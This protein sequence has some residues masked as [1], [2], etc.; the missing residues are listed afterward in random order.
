M[1]VLTFVTRGARCAAKMHTRW[2]N[3]VSRHVLVTGCSRG[4][5]LAVTK[6]LL[7]EGWRVYG[8]ARSAPDLSDPNFLFASADVGQ[9]AS[10]ERLRDEI[11]ADLG[12]AS[13]D[14]VIHCA[15]VQNP[16]GPLEETAPEA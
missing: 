10:V 7:G 4:I 12:D 3:K 15:V 6:A 5:G 14:A 9:V 2:R 8:A 1:R 11:A 13:L 16:V